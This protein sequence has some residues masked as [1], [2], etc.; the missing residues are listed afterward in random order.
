MEHFCSKSDLFGLNMGTCILAFQFK[1]NRLILYHCLEKRLPMTQFDWT[2]TFFEL[3]ESILLVSKHCLF[4]LLNF[5]LECFPNP[6]LICNLIFV[7]KKALK[8]INNIPIIYKDLYL[9]LIY[10]LFSTKGIKSIPMIRKWFSIKCWKKSSTYFGFGFT[11]FEIL[12]E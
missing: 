2:F 11:M 1:S 5:I 12:A 10:A 8:F 7:I 9:G 3:D 4:S 6:Y